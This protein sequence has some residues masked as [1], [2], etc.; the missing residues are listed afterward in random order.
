MNKDCPKPRDCDEYGHVE[1][2]PKAAQQWPISTNTKP[3]R[4][5]LKHGTGAGGETQGS[6]LGQLDG[7]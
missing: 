2:L 4:R 5:D 7:F 1:T 3:K 6:V